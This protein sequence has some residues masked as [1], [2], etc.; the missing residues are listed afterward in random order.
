V[1]VEFCANSEGKF[2]AKFG[3]S[4]SS[5]I[6]ETLNGDRRLERIV[7]LNREGRDIEKRMR[8]TRA[9]VLTQSNL[10]SFIAKDNR[11]RITYVFD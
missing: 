1:A 11:K 6:R 3:K 2:D 8:E 10:H 4:K 7:M 5:S 9:S